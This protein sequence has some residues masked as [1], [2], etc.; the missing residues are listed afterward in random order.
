MVG[1]SD[2]GVSAAAAKVDA[3][4]TDIF[5]GAATVAGQVEDL[6]AAHGSELTTGELASIR[7]TL[8]EHLA[9]G[10][11]ALAGTGVIAAPGVLADQPRWLEWWRTL[12]GS[13]QPTQLSVDLD[14]HN[15]TGYEYTAAEWFDTPRRTGQRVVVGPYVDYAGTDEYLLTFAVP[16]RSGETFAGVAAADVRAAE[17]AETMLPL[18]EN[19][20]RNV[21]LV[22]VFGRVIASTS[23]G[24]LL[25]SL[26]PAGRP[27][28]VVPDRQCWN[29][30]AGLPWSLVR[31]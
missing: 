16:I 30:Y 20:G 19:V 13:N 27:A 18:L 6:L 25:G 21:A 2:L 17:F 9:H 8:L 10:R 31:L 24:A 4:L 23:P 5:A 7:P 3:V 11:P 29:G 12:P 28:E 22:N 26:A 14:P 1:V 15:V